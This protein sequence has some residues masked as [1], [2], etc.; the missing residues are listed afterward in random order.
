MAA[1][2]KVRKAAVRK[3]KAKNGRGPHQAASD[4]SDDQ[5]A[6]FAP[7]DYQVRLVEKATA[8]F[9]APFRDRFGRRQRAAESVLIESPTGSGKTI[10]GLMLAQRLQRKYGYRVGWVAMRRNLLAQAANENRLRGFGVQLELISMF[11]ANPPQV[12]FLI[13]DEAQHDGA[14]T[15]AT[16]HSLIRPKK[17]LGLTATPWRTDRIRLCFEQVL[18]DIGIEQLIQAGYLSPYRHFTIPQY[19][20]LAVARHFARQPKR[21][22]RSLLFFHRYQ[23]CLTCQRALAQ[24]GIQAEVVTATSHRERQIEVFL[25]GQIQVLISMAVLAEGFDC[26]SLRTVFCR[27][28]GKGCTI[29]MCGRV[30][31]TFSGLRSKQIV[32]CRH[33]RY[34]IL[35]TAKPREQYV[36][37]D[38]QWMSLTMN[39]QMEAVASATRRCMAQCDPQLPPFLRQRK[40]L[41]P[42]GI[43][44]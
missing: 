39:Q 12:D 32:Q 6:A 38:G 4:P 7:R 43:E 23:Q 10:M 8:M 44:R 19:T 14:R 2:T 21:W 31:R 29:Q 1:R 24:A 13:V 5:P 42:P 35:R 30:F 40:G 33:T 18:R 17:V 16:L 37:I 34:P 41:V 36:W 3:S 11:D 20:P 22:G 15:M 28:S 26:P 27:P 9:R 25:A